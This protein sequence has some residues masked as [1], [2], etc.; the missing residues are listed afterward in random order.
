MHFNLDARRVDSGDPDAVD[1]AEGKTTAVGR[2]SPRSQV[3]MGQQVEIAVTSENI[4]FFDA[5]TREAI[6]D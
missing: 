3:R 5:D 4:H 6:Y 1:E 2:F